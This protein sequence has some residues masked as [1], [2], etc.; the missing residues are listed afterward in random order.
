[1]DVRRIDTEGL[2]RNEEMKL[3]ADFIEDYN[4]GEHLL[5]LKISEPCFRDIATCEVL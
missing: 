3:F 4:T 1:M 2:T 5:P